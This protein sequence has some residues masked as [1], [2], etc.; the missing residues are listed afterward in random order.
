MD[1]EQESKIDA[2]KEKAS[3]T[4]QA[5]QSASK[6]ASKAAAGDYLGAAKEAL[7]NGAIKK[8]I[9][10]AIILGMIKLAVPILLIVALGS[11]VLG[12]FDKIKEQEISLKASMGSI[13][14]G[15]FSKLWK[16]VTNDYWIDLNDEESFKTYLVSTVDGKTV[17]YRDENDEIVIFNKDDLKNLAQYYY[18][19]SPYD[20]DEAQLKK[21]T[22]EYIGDLQSKGKIK[23]KKYNLVDSY[24]KDL[25][26]QGVS[27]K[28]LRLLG[29]ADYDINTNLINNDDDTEENKA[30]NEENK[31]KV[32]KYI[33]EF[34][35]ADMITQNLH[36]RH[37]TSES[38]LATVKDDDQNQIDGGIYLYRTNN[39][40]A[41]EATPSDLDM[42]DNYTTTQGEYYKV[43]YLPYGTE[44]GTEF[45]TFSRLI[46]TNDQDAKKYFSIKEVDGEEQLVIAQVSRK[47]TKD[48]DENGTDI[49]S[50]FED[51][52]NQAVVGSDKGDVTVEEVVIPYK[53]YIAKYA[54][55]YE[56]LINLCQ[57]TQNPEFVYHVATLARDTEIVLTIYDDISVTKDVTQTYTKECYFKNKENDT[58]PDE[59]Y[60]V[61]EN[62][63][64][65]VRSTT[66]TITE[67][68]TLKVE[69]ADA[70]D[71]YDEYEYYKN[72]Q[73]TLNT[74][75]VDTTPEKPDRL[76]NY[77]PEERD[78]NNN[79]IEEEYWDD[80][81]I[82]EQ[83]QESQNI[84]IDVKYE[85]V[86]DGPSKSIRK[87]KQ[88][89]G[90]LR[91]NNDEQE[92]W[93][94]CYEDG[95]ENKE[96][97]ALYCARDARFDINGK[98]VKYII[99]GTNQ[100]D[101]PLNKLMSGLNM[102]YSIMTSNNGSVYKAD[103]KLVNSDQLYE[104]QKQFLS[105]ND[106]ES[107]Y[108]VS[109]QEIVEYLK[110]TFP[111]PYHYGD[112]EDYENMYVKKWDLVGGAGTPA[113]PVPTPITGETPIAEG[114]YIWPIHDSNPEAKITSKFGPRKAP[115][116]GASTNH[117]GIDLGV[118]VNTPVY[119]TA[120][121]KVTFTG[122][123][124]KAGIMVTIDHQNGMVSKY[125][126]LN[127]YVVKPGQIVTQGQ[128]IA[129][130]GNTGNSTGP[131]LHF[132][133]E[134]S[135]T[136][137][138]PLIYLKG[139]SG[140]ETPPTEDPHP[141]TD[142]Q[143]LDVICAIVMQEA[144]NKYD[145]ALAVMSLFLNRCTS[146]RWKNYGGNDVYK[147]M[148]FKGQSS[149][150]NDGYYK[151]YLNGNY[152]ETVKRAVDDA[153]NKGKRNH[154]YTCC[155]TDTPYYR[156]IHPNGRAIDGNWFF[157]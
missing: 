60:S 53:E 110:L 124:N 135:G 82:T 54:M 50:G 122:N 88:F 114:E 63:T 80:K 83:Y 70:W 45:N 58:I 138:D 13:R 156:R 108:I 31:K 4:K 151:K 9:K 155:R 5:I 40:T 17:A 32:E 106:Y 101:A 6:I 26:D 44:G 128:L 12:V 34:I 153:L 96:P 149:Y 57:V 51:I 36:R 137:V 105:Q 115:K 146:A 84:A 147:Q 126:H 130:S 113:D 61:E 145:G 11:A 123:A 67:V 95:T 33:S 117:G 143:K 71:Y 39:K 118:P 90:L 75:K 48:K 107:A 129:Y 38:D 142:A 2:I 141:V 65:K 1:E 72:M 134:L 23:E 99:P 27:I 102:L 148:T 56:F 14:T 78:I 73:G 3:E 157:D 49:E 116:A 127:S 81:F 144:G 92:C 22:D 91:N 8:R 79:V 152:T 41:I 94:D 7:T 29:D 132:Q 59:P 37:G 109:M 28:D 77:H 119:A 111:K 97:T 52:K 18:K 21:I 154:S 112:V 121:G 140:G 64:T 19:K 87:S 16:R 66:T 125:M 74:N 103:S 120:Q 25:G 76:R 15:F 133:M 86:T 139:K 55:P 68:P 85:T 46:T 98:N 89:L 93:Y 47:V 35:R 131:H 20:L 104:G 150:S 43:E 42:H 69:Y 30:K 10:K 24:I 62:T 100:K 136:K